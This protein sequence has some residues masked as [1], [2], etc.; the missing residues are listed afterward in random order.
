[1]HYIK[2]KIF[3]QFFS[4]HKFESVLSSTES[5]QSGTKSSIMTYAGL[6]ILYIRYLPIPVMGA[7]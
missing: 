6:K 4:L 5:R 3:F 7:Q 2:K 1:M